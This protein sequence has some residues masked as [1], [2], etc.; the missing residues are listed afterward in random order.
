MFGTGP[1][2]VSNRTGTDN[3]Y[4]LTVGASCI[5]L[6]TSYFNTFPLFTKKA[7]AY[8]SWKELRTLVVNKKHLGNEAS[9]RALVAKVNPKKK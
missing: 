9:M 3:V 8:E 7:T 1:K 5:H 6:I 2:A 4:R